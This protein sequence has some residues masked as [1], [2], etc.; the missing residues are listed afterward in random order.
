MNKCLRCGSESD[1]KI[2]AKLISEC[3]YCS[4]RIVEKLTT[5]EISGYILHTLNG[6]LYWNNDKHTCTYY[7]D[8][9][10]DPID[11]PWLPLDI[12]EEKLKLYL[13]FS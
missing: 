10:V 5:K 9:D 7:S 12:T 6:Q 4:I 2:L 3:S 11:L 1:Y 8:V 13:T